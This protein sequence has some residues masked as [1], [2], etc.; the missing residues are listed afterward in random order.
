MQSGEAADQGFPEEGFELIEFGP[1]D[2][3]RNHFPYIEGLFAV[4]GDTPV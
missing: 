2:D 4:F 3:A 1:I